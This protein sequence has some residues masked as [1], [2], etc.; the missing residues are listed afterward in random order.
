[1]P[2]TNDAVKC[3]DLRLRFLLL[4]D[5]RDTR[6]KPFDNEWDQFCE[7]LTDPIVREDKD[8]RAWAPVTLCEGASGVTPT[9]AE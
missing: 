6:G 1:V 9:C 3:G 5:A 4:R 7:R 8:G 2:T